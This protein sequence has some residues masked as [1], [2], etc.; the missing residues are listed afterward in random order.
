MLFFSECKKVLFSPA[1]LIYFIAVLAMYFATFY[2][3]CAEPVSAP[4]AGQSDYGMIAKE[5]P[6]IMMPAATESLVKEYLSNSYAAYPLGFYKDVHLNERKKGRM[7]E[8][9]AALSGMTQEELERL[10]QAPLQDMPEITLPGDLT[11]EQFRILMAQADNLIGGGSKY[12]AGALAGNFSFVPK[13]YEDALNEYEQFLYDDKITGAYARLYCDYLGI[14]AAL[15]P[16]FAAI[17]MT[18]RD[19][20]ARMEQ[21][22]F[23]RR[24]S[25]AALI[26]NRYAALI[27]IMSTPILITA[28]LAQLQVLRLYP[29]TPLDGL[30][31]LRYAAIWLLPN[32]MTAAA[33][34]MLI[35]ELFSELLAFF[36]QGVWWFTSMMAAANGLTGNIGKFTLVIRHNSLFDLT[37]FRNVSGNFLFNRIF[38]MA[39]S[40]AVIVL[41]A[42]IYNQKRKGILNEFRSRSKHPVCKSKA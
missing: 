40:A 23:T 33:V 13:T 21:L 24:V 3:E 25:S 10:T 39:A 16:V 19:K 4:A 34:G 11:Y 28:L 36:A 6:E 41:T 29:H 22:V 5:I 38:F 15:L 31:F 35:T 17:S 27:A 12:S 37:A 2:S 32:I 7:A 8:I 14:A 26:F 30:A 20:K 1:F 18:L 9:V 42:F